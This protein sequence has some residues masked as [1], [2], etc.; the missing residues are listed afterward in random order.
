[1]EVTV[2]ALKDHMRMEIANEGEKISPEE[3]EHIFDELGSKTS[4]III[5]DMD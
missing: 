5:R 3:Q 2:Q 1:M 4:S